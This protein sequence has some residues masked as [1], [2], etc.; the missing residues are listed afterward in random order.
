MDKLWKFGVV[1]LLALA[2]TALP[3]GGAVL[4]V[5]LTLLT[6]GFFGAI[7]FLGYRL[8]RQ[9]HFELSSLDGRMTA[10]LYGSLGLALLTFTATSRLLDQGGP[11]LIVWI[12]LLALASYGLY[13]VWTRYRSYE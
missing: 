9:F 4:D 12:A 7:G 6:I 10:V 1:A 13:F 2:F 3:G 11:G 5:A 8:Y